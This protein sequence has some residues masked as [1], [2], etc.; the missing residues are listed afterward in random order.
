MTEFRIK[1]YNLGPRVVAKLKDYS[2]FIFNT[3]DEAEKFAKENNIELLKTTSNWDF[4]T[5][6][7]YYGKP[8]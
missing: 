4:Y 3:L 7:M 1:A 6:E 2:G 5:I 8:E